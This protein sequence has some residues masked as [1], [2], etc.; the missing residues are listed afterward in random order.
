MAHLVDELGLPDFDFFA[1]DARGHGRSPGARG[2]APGISDSIRDVQTFVE[3]I[4]DT[5]GFAAEDLGVIA[6]SVGAVLVAAWVHDYAPRLR[7]MVL[8]SPAFKVKLYVPF[9]REGLALL[10]KLRGNFF[11]TSYVKAKFLTRDPERMANFDADR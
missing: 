4:R 6:Q 5:H 1:W 3:H 11:V 2:D 8:A 10:Y 7:C 9:A